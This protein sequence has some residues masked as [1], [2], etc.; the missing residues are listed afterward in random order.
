MYTVYALANLNGNIYIGYTSDLATRLKRH[1][2]VLPSRAASYT[3]RKG[4]PWKVIYSEVHRDAK[5]A[6]NREKQLKSAQGRE[7]IRKLL[8]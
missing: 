1:N 5:S 2:K 6:G 3:S 7:F 4:G 8:V